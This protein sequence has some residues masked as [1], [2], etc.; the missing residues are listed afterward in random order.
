MLEQ[1]SIKLIHEIEKRTIPAVAILMKNNPAILASK[2]AAARIPEYY[3]LF[4]KYNA[5]I[6][7]ASLVSEMEFDFSSV[8]FD[9]KIEEIDF[10]YPEIDFLQTD[11]NLYEVIE[12]KDVG[13]EK[14]ILNVTDR[15]KKII[16]DIYRDNRTLLKIKSREFEEVIAELLSHQ[17]FAVELTTKVSGLINC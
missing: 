15:I 10:S 16:I 9:L 13:V 11:Y 3:N 4:E 7:T 1:P 12:N 14:V 17:G 2:V 5:F 8:E 6:D